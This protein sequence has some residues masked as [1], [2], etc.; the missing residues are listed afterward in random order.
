MITKNFP[1][2]F[3][4]ITVTAPTNL[5]ELKIDVNNLAKERR[6]LIHEFIKS[7]FSNLISSTMNVDDDKF[8]HVTKKGTVITYI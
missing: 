2:T 3:L 5:T 7:N 1:Q 8:I 6:K 4:F